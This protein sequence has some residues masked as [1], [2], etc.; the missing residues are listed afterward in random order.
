MM[1][2]DKTGMALNVLIVDDSAAIRKIL[3]RMLVQT[4]VPLGTVLEANDGQEAMERMTGARV[5]LILS[6]INMPKMDGLDFLRALKANPTY[7][8]VPVVMV[9]SE[10]GQEKVLLA[11]QLGAAGYVKKPFTSIQIR[12]KLAEVV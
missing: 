4:K 12:E 3:H 11:L 10:G 2:V 8:D 7:K 1:R 5:G 9:T 6:E